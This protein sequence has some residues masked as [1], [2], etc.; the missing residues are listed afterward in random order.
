MEEVSYE[1]RLQASA[2]QFLIDNG[3]EEAALILLSCSLYLQAVPN[4]INKVRNS[5]SLCILL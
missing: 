2:V 5:L 4:I 1:E 3:E